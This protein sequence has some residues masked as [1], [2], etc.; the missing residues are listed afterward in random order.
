MSSIGQIALRLAEDEALKDEM[1]AVRRDVLGLVMLMRLTFPGATY[2][3]VTEGLRLA[4]DVL[5][6]DLAEDEASGA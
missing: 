3:D 6:L 1:W 4:E 2:E 5:R